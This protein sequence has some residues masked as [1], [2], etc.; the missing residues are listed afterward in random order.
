LKIKT[1]EKNCEA[2]TGIRRSD[3]RWFKADTPFQIDFSF[4]FAKKKH[5]VFRFFC[6]GREQILSL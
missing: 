1:A 6:Y 4:L 3:A 2:I 5:E